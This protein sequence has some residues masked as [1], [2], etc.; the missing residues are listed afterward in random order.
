MKT[1]PQTAWTEK[2]PP[3]EFK[4]FSGSDSADVVIVGGG[5]AGIL[6]AYLLSKAGKKVIVIEKKELLSGATHETTAF[7]T[8]I[9]DTD[10]SDLEKMSGHDKTVKIAESHGRAIDLI[11]KI[12]KE[13]KIE[14]EF[15]RCSNFIYVNDRKDF[16]DLESE[17]GPIERAGI[18]AK[19][20]HEALPG[21]KNG[22][23][24]EV[25]NQGKFHPL[26][27][28]RGVVESIKANGVRI[29][30][31][32]E[33]ISIASSG[34]PKIVTEHGEIETDWILLTTYEPFRQPAG[35]FFKKGM[36]DSFV[37][38]AE[39]E[40]GAVREGTYEDTENPYHYFRVDPV[41]NNEG[42]GAQ[43]KY[44]RIIIGGED[45]RSDIPL[46]EG[47]SFEALEK[48]AKETFGD[49]IKGIRR[50]WDGPILETVDGLAFIGPYKNKKILYAFGFS[51]NGMTYSG[52]SAMMFRDLISGDKNAWT[53]V[54]K[55]DR[56]PRLTSL[57][58][59]TRDYLEE[60][61]NGVFK[62]LGR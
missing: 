13:E 31:H 39:L 15:T 20:H 29:F 8:Q 4:S 36:Y 54:Y 18:K 34:I 21:F 22:G 60:L 51:G 3:M 35:L 44:D 19:L 30:E 2:M 56:V 47:K 6:S 24:I 17:I 53:E 40:K 23:Y 45:H 61:L 12:V 41:R 42:K 58:Y 50:R 62:N 37:L 14:C 48:Y 38:E 27:F 10:F 57:A 26:K 5:M 49:A 28:M 7:L 59:K 25:T 43:E 52:I 9:I 11:E 1:G 55:V 46:P 33:A 16:K 32:S